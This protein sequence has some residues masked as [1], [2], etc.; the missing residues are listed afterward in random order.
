MVVDGKV[1]LE[2]SNT[3]ASLSRQERVDFSLTTFF[4]RRRR[5]EPRDHDDPLGRR[6]WPARRSP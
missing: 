4:A 2:C 3:T 1:D 6:P 5:A